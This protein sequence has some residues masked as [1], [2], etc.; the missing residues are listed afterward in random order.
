MRIDLEEIDQIL[1]RLKQI[2]D[3]ELEDLEVYENGERLEISHKSCE[4]FRFTGLSNR[5][6]LASRYFRE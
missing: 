3:V 5:D 4:E 6:F 2:N 1:A